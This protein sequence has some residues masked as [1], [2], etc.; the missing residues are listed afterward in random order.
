M[1]T[2]DL[3]Y[4]PLIYLFLGGAWPMLARAKVALSHRMFTVPASSQN[5]HVDCILV[6]MLY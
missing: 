6:Y 2:S 3:H 5:Y 1:F 4:N